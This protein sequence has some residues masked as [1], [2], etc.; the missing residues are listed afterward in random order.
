MLY[1]AAEAE[2][3]AA[4]HGPAEHV[5]LVVW[6]G[7][8]PEFVTKENAPTLWELA[9]GGVTFRNHHSVFPTL[10]NV[11]STALATGVFPARSGL[12]ANY[13]YR[14]RLERANF[15]RTDLPSMVK[16][17]DAATDGHYLGAPTIAELVHAAGGRTAIAGGK[18]ASLLHDRNASEGSVTIFSGE[19]VP[20]AA[21]AGLVK[22]LGLFPDAG[23]TPG[24]PGDNWTT[25]ALTES[26][27]AEGVPPYSVLWLSEPDRM[28]HASGP[29]SPESFAAIKSSDGHLAD[30]LAALEKHGVRAETDVFVASDHGF[31]TIARAVDL[32]GL[33]K[34]AGFVLTSDGEVPSKRGEIRLV[35]NGGTVL[36]YI[37]EHDGETA[38]RL[39]EWLQSSDFA[40]VI[41]ARAGVEGTFALQQLH[42]DTADAP[43]VLMTFRW[44]EGRNQHGVAGMIAA[45]GPNDAAGTHGTLSKFDLHNTLIAAGPDF[46]KG[47]TDDAPTSNVDVATTIAQLL[48]VKSEAGFDGRILREAMIR[49]GVTGYGVKTQVIEKTRSIPAGMWR[50]YLRVS[51]CDGETYVDEGNS[52]L[53][54]E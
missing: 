25:R 28:Q 6:D 14:P 48:G 40:G 43:D 26:L 15:I 47:T 44:N 10:T 18:T 38:A 39:I 45:L 12:L 23:R 36:F 20:P 11:N 32:R 27:W 7:M 30:V 5:V 52:E 49:D 53:R 1:P 42:L 9:Q 16:K 17:G 50:Q 21:L 4:P 37:H 31:S 22:L 35:G 13:E 19:T 46:Q 54:P 41:F 51:V 24:V 3:F 29:G 34:T 8:R 33:L 2:V